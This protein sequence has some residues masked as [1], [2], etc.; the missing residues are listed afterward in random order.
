MP[1]HNSHA[2]PFRP[3]PA[4]DWQARPRWRVTRGDTIALGPGKADVLEAIGRTGSISAAALAL[5]MSYRRAWLLVEAMN[6][7]F[8][9]PLVATSSY[10]RRGAVL[11]A[12]GR[13]VLRVYRR[14][15]IR[16]RRAVRADLVVLRRLLGPR[17]S[18]GRADR[19]RP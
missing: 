19:P 3:R 14:I 13:R 8:L 9:R 17:V 4:A 2:R 16:S 15:E 11:T 10:R 18:P 12:E 7:C 6:R 5:G 1:K